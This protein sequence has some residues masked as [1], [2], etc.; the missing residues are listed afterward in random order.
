MYEWNGHTFGDRAGSWM[1]AGQARINLFAGGGDLARL[2]AANEAA[3]RAAAERQSA[4]AGL[5]LEIR[6][7]TAQLEAAQARNGVA[8]SAV[9]QAR[10]S[11]RIIRDRYEAGLAAVNDVLR[12]ANALLDAETQRIS[13]TVDV[14]VARAALDRAVGKVPSGL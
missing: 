10:E 9:L 5:R 6:T 8:R 2:H 13:A 12:A 11:Q 3:V 7:A 1:I 4:E 14:I